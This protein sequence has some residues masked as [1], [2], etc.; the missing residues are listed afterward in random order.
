MIVVSQIL[1]RSNHKL[2]IV[3]FLKQWPTS[4]FAK[5]DFGKAKKKENLSPSFFPKHVTEKKKKSHLA[6]NDLGHYFRKVF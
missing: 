4:I 6:K 3:T 5:T 2:N 1:S